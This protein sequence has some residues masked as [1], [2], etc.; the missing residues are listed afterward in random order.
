MKYLGTYF[1]SF[2]SIFCPPL[3]GT[4]IFPLAAAQE[5]LHFVVA[6]EGQL[7]RFDGE[8]DPQYIADIKDFMERLLSG[9]QAG[10]NNEDFLQWYSNAADL[11]SDF[12]LK[13]PFAINRFGENCSMDK[14][15]TNYVRIPRNALTD[16]TRSAAKVTHDRSGTSVVARTRVKPTRDPRTSAEDLRTAQVHITVLKRQIK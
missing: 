14:D 11:T 13:F 16:S 4:R 7:S 9:W 10:P 2:G 3:W 6:N 12:K 8:E 1:P 5:K 15:R